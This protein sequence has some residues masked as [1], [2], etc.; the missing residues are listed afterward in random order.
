MFRVTQ[1]IEFCYGHRLLNYT[2]KCRFL[3]GHNG[4]A[5]IVMEGE[6]LDRRGMLVDFTD[7]KQSLATWIDATL[8]H[9]MI[10]H[11]ND[12]AV[13]FLREHNEPILTIPENPTAEAIARMI[14]RHASAQG[15]PV[16]EVSLWETPKSFATYRES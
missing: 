6:A 2:G 5:V 11:E 14:Y 9:R 4:K 15:F 13:A 16:A 7:I 8:D 1:H 10:L 12:P 3:H